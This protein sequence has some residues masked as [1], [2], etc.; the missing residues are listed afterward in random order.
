VHR[1]R[2]MVYSV[3]IKV[4]L[5]LSPDTA[6]LPSGAPT[7]PPFLLV[8]NLSPKDIEHLPM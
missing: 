6:M 2:E 1:R 4:F 7:V 3:Q 8:Q 5:K